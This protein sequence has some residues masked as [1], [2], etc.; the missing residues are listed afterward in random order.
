MASNF[1]HLHVHSEY[2]LLDGAARIKDLVAKAKEYEMTS[3]ALTDHGVMYGAMDFYKECKANGIKPILGV[4]GYV[5]NGD[6]TEKDLG[7]LEERYHLILLA[8]NEEGYKNLIKL[9]SESHTEG[10]YYKPR[11]NKELLRKYSKGIICMSACLAGEVSS[12][13]LKGELD[14]ARSAARE[15]KEIFG[16]NNFFLEVQANTLPEQK[17]VNNELRKIGNEL[18]IKLVAT[19][20]IHYI[21]FE[22]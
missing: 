7:R 8:E 20:D 12:L 10:F 14:K 15:Y 9:V 17:L 5:I 21:E 1:V 16:D 13:I 22:D 19:N 2:S 11:M 6:I 18:G 3:I 4:E